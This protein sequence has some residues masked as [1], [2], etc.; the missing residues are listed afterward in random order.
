MALPVQGIKSLFQHPNLGTFII[1]ASVGAILA[2]AG[3]NKFAGGTGV[4]EAVGSNVS[5]VGLEIGSSG[6]FPLFFGIMAAGSELLGG[7]LL[8]LGVLFRP[9]TALLLVTMGVA[10]VTKYQTTSGDFTLYGYPLLMFLV[11]LGLL[12]SGSGK[13]SIVRDG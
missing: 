6:A 5:R 10:T 13:Y 2:F 3:W 7:I 4:L 12:F 9:M 11:L 1:R 8:I